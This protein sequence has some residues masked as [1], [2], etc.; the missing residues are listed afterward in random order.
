M[1]SALNAK[2]SNITGLVTAGTNVTM[3]GSG[4][5]ASPYVINSSGGGATPAGST[6]QIQF[7]NAGAFAA[8]SNLFW[9]NS[10][11][12]LGIGNGSPTNSLTVGSTSTSWSTSMGMFGKDANSE[13]SISISNTTDGT[14]AISGLRFWGYGGRSTLIG[15]VA[16]SATGTYAELA[17]SFVI[18]ANA[19]GARNM[20]FVVTSGGSLKYYSGSPST[21][22]IKEQLFS[23]GNLG[24]SSTGTMADVASAIL[25]LTST[26]KGFLPP[27]MTST[28]A[29]A[30]SSPAQGLMLFVTDTNATF[31]SIGWWGYDGTTWDKLNN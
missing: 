2:L 13:T 14:S 24:L 20:S 16:P 21:T 3:S 30:I 26:T 4:T 12:R 5:S 15:E 10:T 7:N 27:R 8:S 6:G 31:T 18:Y 17:N 29:S 11:N 22:T 25:H 1:Q 23:T 9:D 28:Q 19:T